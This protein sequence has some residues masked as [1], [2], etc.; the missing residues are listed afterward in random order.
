MFNVGG[1]EM[2]MLGVLALLVFGPESLPGVIKNVM[3]TV[4]ALRNAARDF[5]SEVK[6]ALD[7]ENLRQD[8]AKRQRSTSP[9]ALEEHTESVATDTEAPAEEP[10][11]EGERSDLVAEAETSSGAEPEATVEANPEQ[12]SEPETAADADPDADAERESE[13][14]SE[15]EPVE[16]DDD[17]DGPGLPIGAQIDRKTT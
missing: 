14:L 7:E 5:Q 13:P 1:G 15:P 4:N 16:E 11:S 8:R 9:E 10:P 17:P 12:A 2:I 6:S 3:R